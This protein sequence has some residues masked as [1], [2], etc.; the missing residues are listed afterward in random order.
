[1]CRGT[2]VKYAAAG[3][4]SRRVATGGT[5]GGVATTAMTRLA[6]EDDAAQVQA[7]YAPVVRD[8]AISFETEPPGVAEVRRR[9]REVLT[10]FPW[11]VRER[12]GELL[13]YAYAT[14]H[15]DRRAYQ[16]SVEVAVYVARHARGAGVGRSLYLPLLDLLAAQG[17]VTAY[18]GI[19]LPN[20]ASVGLHE[21]LGFTPV[22]VFREAGFKHGAWRDVGWWQRRLREPAVPPAP[23][24]ALPAMPAAAVRTAL[25]SGDP[26]GP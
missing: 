5:I 23:P 2:T 3:G 8:T 12:D 10:R 24:T 15:R 19:T 4:G 22:G 14:R 25:A 17:L 9:I 11:L 16:W 26:P 6:R 20:P 18:A 1:V 7:I 21:A 13:G